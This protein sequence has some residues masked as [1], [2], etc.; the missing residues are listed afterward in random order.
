MH[1]TCSLGRVN[2]LMALRS[3]FSSN[4]LSSQFCPV[5]TNSEVDMVSYEYSESS[6]S[7]IVIA[8]TLPERTLYERKC[9]PVELVAKDIRNLSPL[10]FSE[11]RSIIS[12]SNLIEQSYSPYKIRS[13]VGVF[14]LEGTDAIATPSQKTAIVKA[15]DW[16]VSSKA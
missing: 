8:T 2:F 15:S 13:S 14:E 3:S 7:S 16:P 4:K 1:D 5:R 11:S 9:T 12:T 10:K 6:P